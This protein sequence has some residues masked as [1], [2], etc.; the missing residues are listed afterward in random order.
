MPD[1]KKSDV[2]KR[3]ENLEK[4]VMKISTSLQR[5]H[6]EEEAAAGPDSIQE[7]ADRV[8]GL[9]SLFSDE[10]VDS[11]EVLEPKTSKKGKGRKG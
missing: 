3:V 7:L 5:T 9:E 8:A 10:G 1:P 11:G 6:S 2:L 4:E